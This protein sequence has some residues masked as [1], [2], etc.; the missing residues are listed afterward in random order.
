MKFYQT[1]TFYLV[2]AN[3]YEWIDNAVVG[4]TTIDIDKACKYKNV[5]DAVKCAFKFNEEYPDSK[6]A[7]QK[8]T[9]E[10]TGFFQFDN[11]NDINSMVNV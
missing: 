2:K 9:S 4:T 11:E 3:S 6:F 8:I 1:E 10:E 7:I 5:E